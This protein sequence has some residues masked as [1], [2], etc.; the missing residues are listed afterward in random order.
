LEIV[1][2]DNILDMIE[3][4]RIDSG[5]IVLGP[6]VTFDSSLT[7]ILC[8]VYHINSGHFFCGHKNGNI[9]GWQ[10]NN[11]FINITGTEKIHDAVRLDII[12]RL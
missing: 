3:A 8:I 5:A 2:R 1:N 11:E 12:Y 7:E 10:T 6:N 4:F 9:S